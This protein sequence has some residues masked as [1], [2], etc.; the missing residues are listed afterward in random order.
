M[1]LLKSLAVDEKLVF[2]SL[3]REA[4]SYFSLFRAECGALWCTNHL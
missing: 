4:H 1:A 3:L 2:L